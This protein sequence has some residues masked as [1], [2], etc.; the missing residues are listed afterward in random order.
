MKNYYNQAYFNKRDLLSL[1]VAE[2]IVLF[3]NSHSLKRVLDMGCGTGR[4]VKYFRDQGFT[5]YGCDKESVAIM[6][7]RKIN[8][9]RSIR[10]ASAIK[11]PFKK[12]S[13]DL[14]TSIHVIEHLS[15]PEMKKFLTET[16]RI[17]T[18][19]GFIFLIAPNFGSL[20]RII[21][22]KSW[23]GYEDPTHIRFDTAQS[24]ENLLRKH[25]FSKIQF[26]FPSST[27]DSAEIEAIPFLVRLPK[28]FKI[29][30]NYLLF[31]TPLTYFRN[32][33]WVA[34]QKE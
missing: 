20:L 19:K 2:S 17:L 16:Y 27:T 7:A 1:H 8:V 18:P 3:I 22:G 25:G 23:F 6:C 33:F 5:A 12:N 14:V 29:C 21:Q 13:F 24:I 11:L 30:I 28:I 34:A 9:P 4:L 10:K 31:S 32:G 26:Q 15:K